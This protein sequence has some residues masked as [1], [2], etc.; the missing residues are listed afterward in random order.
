VGREEVGAGARGPSQ[1][2]KMGGERSKIASAM[3]GSECQGH[4]ARFN[5]TYFREDLAVHS[6][7]RWA[8]QDNKA[9]LIPWLSPS[10]V[11]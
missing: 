3:D 4:M 2:L 5:D 11:Y 6:G 8:A 10:Q 1:K 9:C 7:R